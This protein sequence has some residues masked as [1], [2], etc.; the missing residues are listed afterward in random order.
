MSLGDG[1]CQ[2]WICWPGAPCSFNIAPIISVAGSLG[3]TFSRIPFKQ[4]LVNPTYER[5]LLRPGRRKISISQFCSSS[6][7]I[8]TFPAL[9]SHHSLIHHQPP[10]PG[11]RQPWWHPQQVLAGSASFLISGQ[12]PHPA[13]SAHLS[14]QQC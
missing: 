14:Y 12:H 10:P 2:L 5:G 1:L 8:E 13:A 4:E 11:R 3:T 7:G 6:R 9:F